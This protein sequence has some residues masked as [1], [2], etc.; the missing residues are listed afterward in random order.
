MIG[1]GGT[2]EQNPMGGVPYGVNQDGTQNM[3]EEGEVSVGNNVFSDRT[4]MSPE[5]CQ[6]LGLPEGTTPA[7][8]MQQIEAL[9]EQGQIG[10]EEFQEIQQIIFQDQETQKQGAEGNIEQMQS[11]MPSEGIQPNMMQGASMPHEMMQQSAPPMQQGAPEGI[12]PEMVQG[13][14]FGG[15]RWGCR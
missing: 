5:L 8:A 3:V 10:D 2:H 4:Q 9:Y 6:Q 7:Q 15:H 14:G 13:Y 11:E 1:E 12:Q